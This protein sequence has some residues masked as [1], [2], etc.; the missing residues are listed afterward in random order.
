[1]RLSQFR[2]LIADEFGAEYGEV[3]IRDL[4]LSELGDQTAA[5]ALSAGIDP[6]LIWLALCRANQVPLER[7]H[8]KLKPKANESV[9][10]QR[11]E[12]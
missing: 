3:L 12:N 8:G 6:R 11:A 4:V 1:M 10:E 2:E 7:W 5:T 9:A